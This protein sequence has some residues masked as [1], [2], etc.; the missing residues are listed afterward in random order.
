M[1]LTSRLCRTSLITLALQNAFL[2]IIM[3]YSRISTAPSKT[4]SAASAVLMNELLKGSISMLI[5]LKRID[6]DMVKQEAHL[7]SPMHQ[8]SALATYPRDEKSAGHLHGSSMSVPSPRQTRFD[9]N[10]APAS[11]PYEVAVQFSRAY[12][13]PDRWRR[14]M[15]DVFSPDCWKLSIPAVLYVIQNNLQYVAASNLDVATF[16]VTYQMKILTTAF[17][18]VVMLGKKLTTA[19]WLSLLLLAL[20]VGIVQIQSGKA[21]HE[22]AP[23]QI[24]QA[25]NDIV[26]EGAA[27]VHHNA[28]RSEIPQAAVEIAHKMSPL[29]GFS[30]VSAA[31]MTSGLAGVYFEMVLKNSKADLWTRN[32]QL[33]LF[34]LVPA[35]LPILFGGSSGILE[36]FRNF[37]LWAWG[38]VLT[39]VLGGLITAVVIKYSDNILKGFA[40]SLSIVISFLASVGLFAYPITPAFV[41]GSIVVLTATWMY[42]QPPSASSRTFA[43]VVASATGRQQDTP[44]KSR[45][46]V[47]VPGS[48]IGDDA[49]IIGETPR[50]SRT[51]SMVSLLGLNPSSSRAGTPSLPD[52]SS[53]PATG[54]FTAPASPYVS[55][56]PTPVSLSTHPSSASLYDAASGRVHANGSAGR[57]GLDRSQSFDRTTSTE[58]MRKHHMLAKLP[59]PLLE[60]DTGRAGT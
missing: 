24:V 38:T 30:A 50:P 7:L 8:T 2:T 26:A 59:K 14:L 40:T 3:H 51:S 9:R 57:S 17:F 15:R 31:C 53:S 29:T 58:S 22:P 44:V 12:F 23:T 54:F 41:L 13:K 11:S 19:K 49:P 34:S 16:Q 35:V 37:S 6:N 4:Y 10:A 18:S 5:A 43:G 45:V 56:A 52:R 25:V 33:S 1:L 21:G 42:N 27:A 47:A 46:G 32:V 55:H 36:P 20:G 28:L 48:P 60:V 39:Q